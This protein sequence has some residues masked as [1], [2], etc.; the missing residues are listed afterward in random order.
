M[1]GP[2]MSRAPWWIPPFLGRVPDLEPRL[3]RLL[4]LVALGLF[5]ESYDISMLTAAL[6]YIA[7][8]LGMTEASLGGQ[9]GLIRLGALPSVLLIPFID[10]IGRRRV[11]LATIVGMSLATGGTAFTRTAEEFVVLQ[12]LARPFLLTGAAVAVVIVAEEFPPEHRGWGLGMVGALSAIGHGL[13]AALFAVIEHLPYGWRALY[14]IGLAPLLLL[15]HFR[16]EVRETARFHRHAEARHARGDTTGALGGWLEPLGRLARTHPRRALGIGAVAGLAALGDAS[17]YQFTGYFTQ[18]VHGWSPGQY[19][20]MV[21]FAGAM[22]IGGNVVAGRLGDRIGRRIVGCASLAAYPLAAGLFYLGPGWTVPLAW[23][24]I[25]FT[26]SAGWIII[27]ALSAE[28]FPTSHRGTSAGWVALVQTLGWAAGLA[29]V[30]MATE[31]TGDLA[32][33]ISTLAFAMLAAGLLLLF[34]PET[35]RRELE[36]ISGDD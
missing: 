3:V 12:M 11:F 7:G 27:R 10:R 22:G 30:G 33:A 2:P 34:L 36:A 18:T 6:K 13:G 1:E 5:F 31:A 25:V 17:V 28:L 15:P 35:R 19:S 26:G 14:V 20:T 24:L 23:T 29:L 4:G 21:I 9:L 8:D 32:R 16:R